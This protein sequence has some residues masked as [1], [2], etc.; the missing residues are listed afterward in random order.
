[1][2][3]LLGPPTLAGYTAFLRDPAG[4]PPSAAPDGSQAILFSF[5]IAEG[6]VSEQLECINSDI[7][8]LAVY[9]LATDRLINFAPDEPGQTYF[10][11]LRKS[12]ALNSFVPGLIQQSADEATSQ[13]FMIPESLKNLTLADLQMLKTPFGRQY[14]FF[15]QSLGT[16]WGLS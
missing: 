8:T 10:A 5:T 14:L 1:M 6:T 2:S 4:I 3:T 16:L 7:Y 12:F 9:N 15:A 11:D 13:A